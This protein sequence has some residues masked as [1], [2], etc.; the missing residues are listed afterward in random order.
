[1]ETGITGK[2][3]TGNG[4]KQGN[5]RCMRLGLAQAGAVVAVNYYMHRGQR[6]KEPGCGD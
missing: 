5:R 4:G 3:S 1:M 2:S 6:P